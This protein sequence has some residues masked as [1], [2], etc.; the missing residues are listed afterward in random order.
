MAPG[1]TRRAAALV[2]KLPKNNDQNQRLLAWKDSQAQKQSRAEGK[3]EATAKRVARRAAKGAA[4]EARKLLDGDAGKTDGVFPLPVRFTIPE[5]AIPEQGPDH[6]VTLQPEA[7]DLP[8]V[9]V[10]R[11][12]CASPGD[13]DQKHKPSSISIIIEESEGKTPGLPHEGKEGNIFTVRKHLS[14]NPYERLKEIQRVGDISSRDQAMGLH[15][16]Y[17]LALDEPPKK[18]QK[19]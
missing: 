2:D 3:A 11:H 18:I 6:K 1:S 4:K 17:H 19:S 7:Q 15:S 14:M 12:L 5:Q 8:P 13:L 16:Q 9:T 10:R